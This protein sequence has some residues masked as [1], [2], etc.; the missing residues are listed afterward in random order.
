VESVPQT[1]W[2]CHHMTHENPV[3][4]ERESVV[5]GRGRKGGKGGEG[6]SVKAVRDLVSEPWTQGIHTIT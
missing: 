1:K 6:V 5:A 3:S 4:L 2:A